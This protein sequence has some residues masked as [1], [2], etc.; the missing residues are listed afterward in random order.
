MHLVFFNLLLLLLPTQ[1]GLHF[2]PAWSMVLGRRVDYLSPT[3]YVTDILIFLILIFWRP[4]KFLG[5]RPISLWLTSSFIVLFALINIFFAA[6]RFVSAYFWIKVLEYVFLGFYVVST[7][8]KFS[9]TIFYLSIGVLYSSIIAIVQF[10]LQR[11]IGGAFWFLGERT[12]SN[13]SPGIAQFN[14]CKPFSA[15]C[16]L[17]LRAYGTF[18]HP[19]VLGGV[20]AVTLPLIMYE[21]RRRKKLYMITIALGVVALALTFSRSA[22]I[23]WLLGTGIINYKFLK[24]SKLFFPVLLISIIMV[25]FII[26]AVGFQDE[27]V[28]VRQALNNSAIAM[29]NESP[30]VGKGLGNFLVELPGHLPSRQIYF[31]QPAHNIYLL[32][33]AETGVVGFAL[34]VWMMW[35]IFKHKRTMLFYSLFILLM[36]GLVDHYPLTLQQGQLLLTILLS[37]TIAL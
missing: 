17:V 31:L 34:F 26:R 28:V 9:S 8:P 3:L 5:Q 21:F 32:M 7:K 29:I 33:L 12:F 22:W 11:S 14:F 13:M 27:S 37:G 19:N 36:L 6:N 10:I 24:K 25:L 23:A 1:L 16:V 15:T 2:W 20:L 18:P 35:K 4:K 30:I